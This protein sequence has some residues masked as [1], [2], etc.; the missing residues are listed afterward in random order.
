MSIAVVEPE[1]G[2]ITLMFIAL[3]VVLAILR[4]VTSE[5]YFLGTSDRLPWIG[6][7]MVRGMDGEAKTARP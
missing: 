2:N 6:D 7:R 3:A 1:T 4:A 5:H